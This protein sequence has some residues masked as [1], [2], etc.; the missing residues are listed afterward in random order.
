MSELPNVSDGLPP[1][2]IR[3]DYEYQSG[4]FPSLNKALEDLSKRQGQ[5]WDH[6]LRYEGWSI[7]SVPADRWS[8]AEAEHLRANAEYKFANHGHGHHMDRLTRV[9][10]GAC[11]LGGYEPRDGF[12]DDW[13]VNR[14]GP[15][16][17]GWAPLYVE[18]GRAIPKKWKDAF[19]GQLN[20]DNTKY[21]DAL[22]MSIKTF[23]VKW[24]D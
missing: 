21:T 12:D 7:E 23:G 6:A 4:R 24:E 19:E 1:Y 13:E 14:D 2:I 5:S 10:C 15:N 3:K 22:K 8:K 17:A 18:A 9:N 11:C 20:S 16:Y